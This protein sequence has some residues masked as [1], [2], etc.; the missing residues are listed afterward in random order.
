MREIH[1]WPVNSPHTGPIT[2][3]MFPFD[4]VIMDESDSMIISINV[5]KFSVIYFAYKMYNIGKP[6]IMQAYC[7]FLSVAN[8]I[9]FLCL[10]W[11]IRY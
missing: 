4:D 7:K 8:Q 9:P 11:N 6:S 10:I 5:H 2:Q 3:K 1:R